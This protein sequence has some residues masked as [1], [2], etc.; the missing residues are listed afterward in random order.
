MISVFQRYAVIAPFSKKKK[1][2][3]NKIFL[4]KNPVSEQIH[5]R[6]F[7]IKVGDENHCSVKINYASKT[8]LLV[9]GLMFST[10]PLFCKRS[11]AHHFDHV[12]HIIIYLANYIICVRSNIRFDLPKFVTISRSKVAD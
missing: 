8:L 6:V 11:N 12:S 2:K 3:M 4:E 5:K 1:N 9:S 7:S 10:S